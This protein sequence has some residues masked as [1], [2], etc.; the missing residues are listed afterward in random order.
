MIVSCERATD[1]ARTSLLLGATTT[2]EDSGL[3]AELQEQ[4]RRDHPRIRVRVIT[5]GTGEILALARSRDLDL[6]LTHDPVAES[7]F[8]ASGQ[9]LYRRELMYNDFV[10]AGPPADPANVRGLREAA[11]AL[12][13]IAAAQAVFVSRGDDSGTHRKERFLWQEAG[14]DV[15]GRK[16]SWYAEAGVG[17][18]EALRVAAARAA[19]ILTDRATYL[20]LRDRLPLEMLVE[21]DARLLNRYGIV[22]VYDAANGEAADSFAVWL[23]S[24]RGKAVIEGYG[25]EQFQRSLFM[26]SQ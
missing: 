17:M 6:T 1:G 13:R 19:Y 21:G 9:G 20:T 2:I 26:P 5:G 18:G 25:R 23:L 10:I 7:T 15:P 24:K 12:R 22:R 3:L 8:V 14:L 16:P 11:E 4:F